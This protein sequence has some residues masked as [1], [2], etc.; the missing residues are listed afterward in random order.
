V[1]AIVGEPVPAASGG[2]TL[3][4]VVVVNDTRQSVSGRVRIRDAATGVPLLDEAFRADPDGAAPVG[5]LEH[6]EEQALWEID[7]TAGPHRQTNH[8][9]AGTPPFDLQ[10]YRHWLAT[11]TPFM[12]A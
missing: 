7:L 8:Y 1:A 10:V 11:R 9:L 6:P 5:D 2:R 3:H 4:P 12:E